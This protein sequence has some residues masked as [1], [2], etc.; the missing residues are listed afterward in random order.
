MY[1][2]YVYIYISRD[3]WMV[4]DGYSKSKVG[5]PIMIHPIIHTIVKHQGFL[6]WI[7]IQKPSIWEVGIGLDHPSS[8]LRLRMA[9]TNPTH[10]AK[11][12]TSCINQD[13]SNKTIKN[14]PKTQTQ[15]INVNMI[16]H[17]TSPTIK[18]TMTYHT[19]MIYRHVN[20]S[21]SKNHQHG[22]LGACLND[23]HHLPP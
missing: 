18:I 1:R 22:R 14:K 20:Q 3:F 5:V 8:C 2:I 16:Q 17:A 9:Q 6:L 23:T 10:Q 19:F 21:Q 15:I 4:L 11:S 7:V 12:R 13:L